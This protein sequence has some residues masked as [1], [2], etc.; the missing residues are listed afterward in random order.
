LQSQVLRVLA[1]HRSPDSY[2]AGGVAINRDGPRF[3]RDIVIFQDSAERLQTAADIDAETLR[4]AGYDVT[5]LAIRTGKRDALVTIAGESVL[6]EWVADSDFRSFPRYRTNCSVT[7]C[8]A[9]TSR[10]TK[11]RLPRIVESRAI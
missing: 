6:L 4:A 2:I 8:I 7:S 9:W 5:L 3:S 1:V 11:R 10:Q